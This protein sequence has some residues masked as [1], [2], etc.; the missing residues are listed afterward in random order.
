MGRDLGETLT[1]LKHNLQVAREFI[2]PWDQFYDDVAVPHCRAA[3][4]EPADNPRLERCVAV[5]A[6]HLYREPTRELD[7]PSFSHVA[8]HGFWHG[9][10][11]VGGRIAICFFFEDI[12]VGLVGFMGS[13]PGEIRLTRVK[14]TDLPGEGGTG[15]N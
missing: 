10:G 7:G 4:G 15:S 9:S 2:D 13:P 1:A 6:G 14:L 3:I 12:G 8:E 11:R 5:V